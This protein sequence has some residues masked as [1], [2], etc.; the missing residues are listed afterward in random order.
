MPFQRDK[1]RDFANGS[2]T[3]LSLSRIQQ[4]LLTWEGELAWDTAFGSRLHRL[5]HAPCDATTRAIART[6]VGAVFAHALP[7]VE[8][9][10]LD[11]TPDGSGLRIDITCAD[12]SGDHQQLPVVIGDTSVTEPAR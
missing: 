8:L 2:G 11:V 4:A 6:Y 1:K 3:Q 9:V 5:T 12:S 7:G 10:H